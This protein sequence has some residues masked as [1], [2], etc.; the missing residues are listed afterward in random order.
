MMFWR[1]FRTCL[2]VVASL[3]YFANGAQAHVK[4]SGA[5]TLNLMMCASGVSKPI[6]LS[7]PGAPAEELDDH[8]C[9]DCLQYF[10]TEPPHI[11]VLPAPFIRAKHKPPHQILAVHPRAPLWPGAP[12]QGPPLS[13]KA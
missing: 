11:S 12:P 6:A 9:G 1:V 2:L 7:I 8:C 5:E 10:A 13:L 3:G 4:I